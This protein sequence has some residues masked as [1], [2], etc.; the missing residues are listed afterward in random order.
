MYN[1]CITLEE[2]DDR[3]VNKLD[4]FNI[5]RSREGHTQPLHNYLHV[6]YLWLDFAKYSAVVV[7]LFSYEYCP[8][9]STV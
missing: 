2:A 3:K 8:E 9:L 7:R 4:G 6:C 5:Q 1:S